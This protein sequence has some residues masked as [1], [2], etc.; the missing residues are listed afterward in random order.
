[1]RAA[2]RSMPGRLPSEGAARCNLLRTTSPRTA[3]RRIGAG[4][5]TLTGDN[6]YT[7]QLQILAGTLIL[8]G[9]NQP[10]I[11]STPISSGATLQ[12]GNGGGTGSLASNVTNNGL[13]II[14]RSNAYNF[15]E[16]IFGTRSV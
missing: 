8:T 12:I 7:G 13:F 9:D 2:R 16:V 11:T 3:T 6:T 10:S 5:L 15:D 1:M 4:T 14:N